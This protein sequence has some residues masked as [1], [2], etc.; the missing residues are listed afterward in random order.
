MTNETKKTMV[1]HEAVEKMIDDDFLAN[2]GIIGIDE[3]DLK[4]LKEGS[5]YIDGAT[6]DGKLNLLGELADKALTVVKDAHPHDEISILLLKLRVAK[7]F[8]LIMCQ[9]EPINDFFCE[10]GDNILVMWGIEVEATIPD[11]VRVCVLGG[12]KNNRLL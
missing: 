2:K 12:F 10:L 6:V 4:K 7:G 11:E 8:D 3:Y 9:L 1:N 5:D